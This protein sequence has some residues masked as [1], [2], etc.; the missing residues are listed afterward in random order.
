MFVVTYRY[1]LPVDKTRQYVAIEQKAIQ[2]YLEH[3]CLGVEIYRDAEDPRYWMELNKFE[4]REHY[5]RVIE[6]VEKDTRIASL[7]E[8]LMG[9]FPGGGKAEK[10]TY[11]RM[12]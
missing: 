1:M 6:K 10:G 9:I 2:I 7:F 3:G 8:E 12:L 4:D 5:D 11:L